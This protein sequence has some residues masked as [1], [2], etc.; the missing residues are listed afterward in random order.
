MAGRR[1]R[2]L[3][4][5]GARP[6]RL[7]WASTGTKN[8]QYS[9]VKYVEPLIGSDTVTTMPLK[10]LAA[11]ADHGVVAQTLEDGLSHSDAVMRELSLLGIEMDDVAR[12]HEN[13]GIRKFI[14]AYDALVDQLE[15]SR[16]EA[17]VA[18]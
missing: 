5:S 10:T 13:E 14:D 6:Q 15:T 1:W 9:D 4:A 3:A 12:R 11:F 17:A 2:T 8:P 18:G 16:E 7:L